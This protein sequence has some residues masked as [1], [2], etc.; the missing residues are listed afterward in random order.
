MTKLF[1]NLRGLFHVIPAIYSISSQLEVTSNRV[2]DGQLK[3]AS[4]KLG[5]VRNQLMSRDNRVLFQRLNTTIDEV[6]NQ[7]HPDELHRHTRNYI[8]QSQ[9]NFTAVTYAL[10]ERLQTLQGELWLNM[11]NY[12][13]ESHQY[14]QGRIDL[15]VPLCQNLS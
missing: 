6:K 9:P 7:I 3:L 1:L 11:S 5:M 14:T 12:R 15:N 8:S 4:I 2:R 10:E 13:D